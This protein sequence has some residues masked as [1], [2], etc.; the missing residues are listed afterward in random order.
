ML[1]C[2]S[3]RCD[4]SDGAD[5]GH[6]NVPYEGRG[7]ARRLR[8]RLKAQCALGSSGAPI[9]RLHTDMPKARHTAALAQTTTAARINQTSVSCAGA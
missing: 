4:R 5:A 1:A 7:T 3:A 9:D 6:K 2:A 8:T